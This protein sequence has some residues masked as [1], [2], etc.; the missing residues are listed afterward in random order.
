MKTSQRFDNLR[1]HMTITTPGALVRYRKRE[2]VVLPSD[3]P[4][5]VLLRALGGNVL[6]Q[7]HD[8]A[9]RLDM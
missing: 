6:D 7:V 1:A 8:L 4:N 3:D 2:W 9:A 5:L